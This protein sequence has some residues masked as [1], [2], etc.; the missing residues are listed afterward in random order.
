VHVVHVAGARFLARIAG[1]AEVEQELAS[2]VEFRDARAVVA[3]NKAAKPSDTNP[4]APKYPNPLNEITDLAG[5]RISYW[6]GWLD[7]SR[8]A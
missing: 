7:G 3:S 5:V 8:K 2:L 6:P 4:A 1:L